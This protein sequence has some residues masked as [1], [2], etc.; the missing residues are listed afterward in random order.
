[1]GFLGNGAEVRQLF[2]ENK[3]LFFHLVALKT[4]D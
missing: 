2:D 4:G 3:R 1:M